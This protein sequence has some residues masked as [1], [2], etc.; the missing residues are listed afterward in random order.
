MADSSGKPPTVVEL[1]W[2]HDLVLGGQSGKAR[3]TVDSAGVAGPSP[4]QALGF[5]VTGCMAMDLIHILRKGRFDLKGL[6]ADLR[7]QRAADVPHRFTA[8]GLHFTVTGD[9][10]DE[11]VQRAIDLSRDK[12]CSV[13]HSMRED[14]ELAVTF[15]VTPAV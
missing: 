2:E 15:T 7:A 6:K 10:P 8:I 1:I 12:Y 9:I 5:A 3:L 11:Q 14:I 13:W 4:M